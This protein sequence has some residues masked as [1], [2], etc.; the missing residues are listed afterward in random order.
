MTI[1]FRWRS[2]DGND[3]L[4]GYCQSQNEVGPTHSKPSIPGKF[5]PRGFGKPN[6][7]ESFWRSGL[8]TNKG[9]VGF[10][11][12]IRHPVTNNGTH[13]IVAGLR[14]ANFRSISCSQDQP[15]QYMCF[16]I[17]C[18]ALLMVLDLKL[19]KDVSCL[20]LCQRGNRRQDWVQC[21]FC[22]QSRK[23]GLYLWKSFPLFSLKS[24]DLRCMA[25][26]GEV[27]QTTKQLVRAEL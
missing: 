15:I 3:Y 26:S 19:C 20:S 23:V 24:A 5:S 1:L 6:E 14:H 22:Q 10:L 17:R 4:C 9:T 13:P 7:R 21:W 16:T 18:Q 12:E 2:A 27:E 11:I 25:A 8:K